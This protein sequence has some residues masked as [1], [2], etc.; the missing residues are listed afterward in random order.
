[1]NRDHRKIHILAQEAGGIPEA[2][3]KGFEDCGVPATLCVYDERVFRR[4]SIPDRLAHRLKDPGYQDDI[5]RYFNEAVLDLRRTVEAGE[6]R[7][8]VIMKGNYLEQPGRYVLARM[9]IPLIQ[10]TYDSLS[11]SPMQLDVMSLADH[12]Y[13]LDG[14][15]TREYCGRDGWLPLGY[16]DHLFKKGAGDKDIDVLVSGSIGVLY[17]RRRE[18]ILKLGR[19]GIAREYNCVFIGTTGF[20]LKDCFIN[21]GNLTWAAKRVPPKILGEYQA[22]AKIC[23]N[24]HQDD[25]TWPVNLS[26]FSIP[27]SASCQL[28][29][30]RPYFRNFMSPGKDYEEFDEESYLE[31]IRFLLEDDERRE[32]ITENGYLLS[33]GGH[34]MKARAGL[35]LKKIEELEAKG[36]GG[37]LT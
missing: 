12:V 2:L 26:F 4:R 21:P 5:R 9:K 17:R 28:L 33:A 32:R 18:L 15:D 10:W 16:N 24:I 7:A 8:V 36:R 30:N 6:C 31:K 25:G 35:I 13:C 19:S 34:T 11:R 3:R 14:A 1:M 20:R 27:G 22:R 23:V 37:K 29:E